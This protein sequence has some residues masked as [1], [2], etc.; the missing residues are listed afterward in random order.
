[1]AGAA[2]SDYGAY[3]AM[4]DLIRAFKGGNPRRP[5]ATGRRLGMDAGLPVASPTGDTPTRITALQTTTV[6]LRSS[7]N[8]SRDGRGRPQAY[9]AWSSLN[10]TA[11][12]T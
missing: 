9:R 10:V 1:M 5:T 3:E 12:V 4:A 8:F 6:L 7:Q 11:L 2:S